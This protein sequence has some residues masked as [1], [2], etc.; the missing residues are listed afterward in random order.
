MSSVVT[1]G[2][3]QAI[4]AVLK[5]LTGEDAIIQYFPTYAIINFT[6][7]QASK[8]RSMIQAGILRNSSKD[9]IKINAIPIITP[10]LIQYIL[11]LVTGIFITGY[12]YGKRKKK[13]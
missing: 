4:N 9:D 3:A 6:P 11:P 13:K 10:Y 2:K 8:I 1:V 7:T 5:S 12:L